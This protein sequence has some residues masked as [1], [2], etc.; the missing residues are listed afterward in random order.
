MATLRYSSPDELIATAAATLEQLCVKEGRYISRP[1]DVVQ[2]LKLKLGRREREVFAVVFLDNKHRV[3]AFEE[4]FAGTVNTTTVHPRE[5][6]R[7]ALRLNAAAIILAHNHPSGDPEPSELDKMTTDR[8]KQ[9]M[10]LID[11]R[12]LDHVV[13]GGTTHTSFAD[14]GLMTPFSPS[15]FR[16]RRK[17]KCGRTASVQSRSGKSRI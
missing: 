8:V 3:L 5:I 17:S 9:V 4:L 15:R 2:L 7:A 12:V 1:S 6:A 10:E 11:V 14:A 16:K 13:V